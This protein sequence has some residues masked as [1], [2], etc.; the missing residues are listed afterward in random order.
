VREELA[1]RQ[2]QQKETLAEASPVEREDMPTRKHL[3]TPA[4]LLEPPET[5]DLQPSWL[6]SSV[7][8]GNVSVPA[9]SL[10]LV[11]AGALAGGMG[12]FFG[13]QSRGHLQA[14]RDT[15]FRDEMVSH[16]GEAV[17]NARNANFL[18]GTAA[19]LTTSAIINWWV[20]SGGEPSAGEVAR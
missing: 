19:V 7:Y 2:L 11:V 5:R 18:F 3:E 15:A 4:V 6:K 17:G 8:V 13:L 1:D 16:H 12:G 20:T 9:P 10:A 14:A